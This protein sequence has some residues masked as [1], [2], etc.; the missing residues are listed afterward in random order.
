MWRFRSDSGFPLLI[1]LLAAV[2]WA[3]AVSACATVE[4]GNGLQAAETARAALAAELEAVRKEAGLPGMTAAVVLPDGEV[5]VAAS[6]LADVESG[7]LMRPDSLMPAGSIGKTFVA[8]TALELT[9]EGALSLDTPIASR[10]GQRDWYANIPN[11]ADITLR[12][13]L[14]HSSGIN[15]DYIPSPE[16]LPLFVQTFGPDGVEIADLGLKHTDIAR[17]IAN[18]SPE[19][20]AGKRIRLFGFKLHSGGVAD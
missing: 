9:A 2:L 7:T 5:V 1:K 8:A 12:M 13:L 16:I 15:A 14:N 10:L 6:G 3:G 18:S 20:P 17:A 19:F 11:G 4:R